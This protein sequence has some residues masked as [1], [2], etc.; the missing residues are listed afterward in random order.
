MPEGGVP[1]RNEAGI[2]GANDVGG[3]VTMLGGAGF[4]GAP[5]DAGAAAE[6]GAAGA[7]GGVAECLSASPDVGCSC[8]PH[9]AHEYWFC[10]QY[11]TFA[12]A[13]NRCKSVT[14]HLP[15]IE[16]QAEDDWLFA[17][18]QAH[19]LGEYFLGA[20]DATTPDVWSWLAGG[21]FWMGIADG[22]AS[23]YAHWSPNEPNASGDCLV[24]QANGPWD[25]RIC[26]DQR[27]YVCES[28]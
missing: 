7:G 23:G 26:T 12:A 3:S 27:R 17:A 4:G 8:E 13:E 9:G 14:M 18:A 24:V 2:G 19:T 5:G 11:L 16:T 15:K 10:S 1:S 20:T 28:Q 6:A 21:T 22:T 25:D